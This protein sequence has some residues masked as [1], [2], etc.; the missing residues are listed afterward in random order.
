V[1]R[2]SL[3]RNNS[4][5]VV[6]F[7][8]MP[9]AGESKRKEKSDDVIVHASRVAEGV[10][11]DFCFE[12]CQ[13]LCVVRWLSETRKITEFLRSL[14]EMLF[15]FSPTWFTRNLSSVA[16]CCIVSGTKR[17]A[18]VAALSCSK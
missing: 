15:P 16:K 5:N 17:L 14:S 3:D 18:G 8:L 11:G 4:R 6:V 9:A 10:D 1:A 12:R 2:G 13:H 7:Q